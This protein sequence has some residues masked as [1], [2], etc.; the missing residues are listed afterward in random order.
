MI[1]CPVGGKIKIEGREYGVIDSNFEVEGKNFDIELREIR[2][3]LA[4]DKSILPTHILKIY[5]DDKK[6][7]LVNIKRMNRGN[8]IIYENKREIK[9]KDI[10]S[11][12]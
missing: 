4:G 11:L 5:E 12:S 3:H 6:L 2:L 1:I 8:T 10:V 7:V 9:Q